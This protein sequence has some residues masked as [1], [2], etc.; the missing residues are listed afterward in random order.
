MGFS[1]LVRDGVALADS[2]T[3]SLQDEVVYEPWIGLDGFGGSEYGP[4]QN[5]PAI[6]EKSDSLQRDSEGRDIRVDTRINIL[7]PILANG[8]DER[9]E[10]IDPRDRFTL[11]D[12]TTG[13]VASVETLID[14]ATGFGYYQIVS[15][16]VKL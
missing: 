3:S 7:K 10:P 9:D 15:L 6:I 8:A 2:L 14:P 12:G 16:G 4:P 13:P 5:I 11:P 1:K